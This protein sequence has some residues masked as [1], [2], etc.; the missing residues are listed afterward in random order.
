[1][2]ERTLP[3]LNDEYLN[4]NIIVKFNKLALNII[5]HNCFIIETSQS[6]FA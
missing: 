4:M 3:Q 6:I 5:N 1:M 2:L